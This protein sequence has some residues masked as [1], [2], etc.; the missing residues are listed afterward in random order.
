MLWKLSHNYR[1]EKKVLWNNFHPWMSFI[2][3][4]CLSQTLATLKLSVHFIWVSLF[5]QLCPPL[6][7]LMDCRTPGFAVLHSL[8][9]FAHTH[10]HWV[11]DAIQPSHPLL[12]PLW[13]ESTPA[14]QHLTVCEEKE[15]P[16][17]YNPKTCSSWEFSRAYLGRVVHTT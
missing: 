14:A 1:G 7:D 6:C 5:S 16:T 13:T 8:P 9:E 11:S 12:P 15:V 4:Q 3:K 2:K 10:V 17:R